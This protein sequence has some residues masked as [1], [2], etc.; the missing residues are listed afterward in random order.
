ME[1]GCSLILGIHD[2]GVHGQC[3]AG[4]NHAPERIGYERGSKTLAAPPAIY[5]Q[6]P[7][8]G[9]RNGVSR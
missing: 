1:S 8:Q 3:L 9:D 5:G 2:Y 4:M 6:S 7:Y